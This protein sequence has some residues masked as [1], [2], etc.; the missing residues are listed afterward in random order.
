MVLIA[1]V[2]F[3]GHMLY[4]TYSSD[5]ISEGGTAMPTGFKWD[6]DP[7]THFYWQFAV[8]TDKGVQALTVNKIEDITV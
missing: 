8:L 3:Y 5:R 7:K 6:N 1:R 2:S 4:F